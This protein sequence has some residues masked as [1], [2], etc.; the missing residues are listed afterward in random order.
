M[1]II[2]A[3]TFGGPS[4]Q[5]V[6]HLILAQRGK[7][8]HL[9]ISAGLIDYFL[10]RTHLFYFRSDASGSKRGSMVPSLSIGAK[11]GGGRQAWGGKGGGFSS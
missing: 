9:H 2:D 4:I 3:H 11:G 1:V 7:R 8:P 10:I 6:D 5:L